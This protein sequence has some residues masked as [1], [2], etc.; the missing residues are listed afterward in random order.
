MLVTENTDTQTQ[1]RPPSYCLRTDGEVL[2]RFADSQPSAQAKPQPHTTVRRLGD[3]ETLPCN[4][5]GQLYV[6]VHA[7]T[8]TQLW[9][10]DWPAKASWCGVH[11]V[12]HVARHNCCTSN[13]SDGAPPSVKVC[14]L[15]RADTPLAL[16]FPLQLE[17]AYLLRTGTPPSPN[18]IDSMMAALDEDHDGTISE[19]EYCA[20][21]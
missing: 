7:R 21:G 8:C 20:L 9:V 18:L 17:E 12:S 3:S 5:R 13:P 10:S 4:A 16:R 2:H 11:P 14:S 6:G 15:V 19:K 1:A